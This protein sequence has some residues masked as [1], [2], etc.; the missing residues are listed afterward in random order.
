M[1]VG[2]GVPMPRGWALACWQASVLYVAFR[3][4]SLAL[5]A[6]KSL[7]PTL[8]YDHL[9]LRDRDYAGIHLCI[10]LGP[11]DVS[12]HPKVNNE[13]SMLLYLSAVTQFR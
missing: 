10:V 13:E 6:F 8:T 1:G 5:F 4:L 3:I 9:L 11:F 2:V 7:W 12:S